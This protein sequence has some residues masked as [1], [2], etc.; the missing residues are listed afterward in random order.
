MIKANSIRK[1]QKASYIIFLGIL[2]GSIGLLTKKPV[3]AQTPVPPQQGPVAI[4][5]ATIH[6]VSHGVIQH[7]T[8]V[9][10]EGIIIATGSGIDIPENAEIIDA[11]GKHVYPGFIH[12]HTTLGLM[13]IARTQEST[14]LQETGQINPNIRAQVAFHPVSEHLAVAAVHGVTT[15]VPSLRGSLIAGRLAAMMT[16]GWTWEEMTIREGLGMVINWPSMRDP[17]AYQKDIRTL[18]EAFDKARRYQV[19]RQAMSEGKATHHPY[20]IRWESMI[21]VLAGDMPVFISVGEIRQIQAAIAWVEKEGLKAVLVGNRD[22]ELVASQLAERNI[23]V[24][25]SGVISGPARQWE[26]YGQAYK[27]P[28]QLFEAGV[29]FCIAGDMGAASAYRIH[30]HAASAVAFGL[31]E[32]EALRA[33]TINAARILGIDDMLGSIEPGKEAT[34]MITDGNALELWTSKIQVFIRGRKIEMMDKHLRLY[35]QYMEK[36]RQKQVPE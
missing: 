27:T 31:P 23:P 29:D 34:L 30:H 21:P 26:G 19:A 4:T 7:G 35:E 1:I 10:E 12:G 32:E 13:E 16:D 6:T 8:V 20:D 18:Q 9:F 22:M 25:L 2:M 36:H 33:I 3:L 24:I 17:D 5:G 15:V 28:L 11:T 14:D